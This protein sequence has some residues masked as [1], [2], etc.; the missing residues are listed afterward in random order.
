MTAVFKHLLDA[1]AIPHMNARHI[2][3]EVYKDNIGSRKVFEKNGFVLLKTVDDC[4]DRAESKGG[5]KIGL[6]FLEWKYGA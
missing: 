6:S 3:V 4:I 5:G 2:K 1:W